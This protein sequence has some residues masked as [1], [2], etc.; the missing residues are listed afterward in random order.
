MVY[1]LLY[2][3]LFAVWVTAELL[4]APKG[5][6][7]NQGFHY[8][9]PDEHKPKVFRSKTDHKMLKAFTEKKNRIN[10]QI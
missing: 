8:G 6:E 2:F 5:F 3:A 1:L 7:D 4:L 10:F 9:T